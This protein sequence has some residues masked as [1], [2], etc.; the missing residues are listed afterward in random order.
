[1][2]ST[3]SEIKLVA[4]TFVAISPLVFK[5]YMISEIVN[6]GRA[7]EPSKA[8]VISGAI[9]VSRVFNCEGENAGL[10]FLGASQACFCTS[11]RCASGCNCEK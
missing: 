4:Y 1:V 9:V 5:G 6:F 7:P 11:Q 2:A 3:V 10:V 8:V